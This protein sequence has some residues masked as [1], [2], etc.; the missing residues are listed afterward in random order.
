MELSSHS[1]LRP[2]E[3]HTTQ[4]GPNTTNTSGEGTGGGGDQGDLELLQQGGC[5]LQALGL[6][7]DDLM[8]PICINTIQDA[9]VT[10]CGHTFCYHCI[11]THL[12]NKHSCPSCANYLTPDR[13]YP[14]FLLSKVLERA[15]ATHAA[16]A[17][18]L[19]DLVQQVRP[20]AGVLLGRSCMG[21]C[22][23]VR[24]CVFCACACVQGEGGAVAMSMG[25]RAKRLGKGWDLC[26]H[27]RARP[28]GCSCL[29]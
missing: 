1:D 16:E 18:S 7:P 29:R 13:I 23:F 4:A 20:G 17:S 19:A 24:V 22:V 21:G 10:S 8:C 28:G 27:R 15:A 26:R 2:S 25:R 6:K 9:F 5:G 12:R 14:N 3:G 11:T